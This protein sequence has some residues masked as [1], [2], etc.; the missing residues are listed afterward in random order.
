LFILILLPD[1]VDRNMLYACYFEC[2]KITISRIDY[3]INLYL[4]LI[5]APIGPLVPLFS[6]LILMREG[7]ISLLWLKLRSFSG[8]LEF[9]EFM[10]R[11]WEIINVDRKEGYGDKFHSKEEVGRCSKGA[12]ETCHRHPVPM[13]TTVSIME[14]RHLSIELAQVPVFLRE[15]LS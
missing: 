14:P 2:N 11:K 4:N 1:M 15:H 8:F 7:Q 13:G 10:P 6:C 3:L 5:L 9:Q 12:P